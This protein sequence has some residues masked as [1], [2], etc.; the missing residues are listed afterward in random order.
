VT[1]FVFLA[2]LLLLFA[3]LAFGAR[4]NSFTIDE[5]SHLAAG[6]A[7]LARGASWTVPLRGH[8]LL[9]D[10]W[11]ALPFYLG[12]PGIPLESLDGWNQDYLR[13]VEAF[14]PY[15]TRMM[16]GAQVAGRTPAILLTVLLAVVIFRWGAD[17]WGRRAGLLAVGILVFDPT[18]LA[19]GRLVTNDVGV[20][21]LGTWALYLTWRWMKTPTWRRAA[22]TGVVLGLTLVA[23]G[24]GILWVGVAL[25][26]AIWMGLRWRH[27]ES[28]ELRQVIL[29]GALSFLIL[30]GMYGFALGTIPGWLAIPVPASRHWEGL[31]FQTIHADKPIVFALG[32]WRET[33]WLW[34]FPLAFLIKNPLPILLALFLAVGVLL[35]KG[36]C[37][38]KLQILGSFSVPYAVVAIIQ[39]PN[40]GYR[41][42][43]PVHPVL[44]LLIA[45]GIEQMW[46]RLHNIGRWGVVVLGIWYVAGTMRVFP[47][48][49]AFFNEIVGGPANGWRYLEGSNTDWGQG[50]VALR[51]FREE[52]SLTF[53]YS[54]TEGYAG[55]APY[56]LWDKPLPPLKHA[57]EPLFR[58]WL[59]PEPGD[60]VINP[61]NFAWFRYHAPDAVIAGTLFYYRVDAAMAPTWLAQCTVPAAPLNK[62]AVADGF[63]EISLR[64]TA[65]DCSQSWVYPDG[66]ATRGIYALHGLGLE[67]ATL[68]ERLHLAPA[69]PVDPF[70]ARHLSG[71]PLAFRQ[72]EDRALPAF[73]LFE[74]EGASLPIAPSLEVGVAAAA[75]IPVALADDAFHITPLPLNGPFIF[76]GVKTYSLEGAL[77]VETWW[78]VTEGPVTRPL[79]VMAHLLDADGAVLGVA[80][81]LGVSPLAFR[82]GDVV[83]QKHRFPMPLE[84][85]AVWLRTGAY[86]L[87]DMELWAV[88][89]V[90]RADALF[91]P[92]DVNQ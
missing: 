87:D 33:G 21:A 58:P 80:D 12:D 78:R 46:R 55:I 30:W 54:G 2:L 57:L 32:E 67:P 61:D 35:R 52:N 28:Y 73:A 47:Y 64:S 56:D 59:F 70:A 65:F 89:A 19:H 43:I 6:Y 72:W 22:A 44:Y 51:R 41:H 49:L 14:A 71:M 8:P 91:V 68:R 20:T 88:T 7:F 3:L 27:S 86:W 37:W 5:P 13:Y 16:E 4:Q 11:E 9:V 82:A 53:S 62:D 79:S 75:T 24:S 34:F 42:M 10:A 38:H 69:R 90:P 60:Y 48:N 23:K 83:V 84:G 76:L 40:V 45:A 66:G 50:W 39:G 63:G 81:G 36:Q 15:V 29:M 1:R 26:W 31:L 92:L 85:T 18:L 25:G 17:L 77:E 74:W